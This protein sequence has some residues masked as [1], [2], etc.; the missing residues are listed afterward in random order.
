MKILLVSSSGGH[1][2]QLMRIRKCI[3]EGHSIKIAT[4]K[5]ED[6]EGTADYYLTEISRNPLNF[7]IN[8]FE[9][10][11]ILFD[12]KPDLIISTGAGTALNICFLSKLLGKKI[13]YF[14]TLARIYDLSMTGKILYKFHIPTKFMVQWPKLI[15]KYNRAEYWGRIL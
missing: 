8:H 3:R 5:R 9:A 15:N 4:V 12:Y 6:T 11:K 2:K 7:M 14:E 10:L 1:F 13:L